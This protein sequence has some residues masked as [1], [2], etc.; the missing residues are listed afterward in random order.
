MGGVVEVDRLAR[1]TDNPGSHKVMEFWGLEA[2]VADFEPADGDGS[3]DPALYVVSLV[4]GHLSS[5]DAVAGGGFDVAQSAGRGGTAAGGT[6]GVGGIDDD[7]AEIFVRTGAFGV[8]LPPGRIDDG[9]FAVG[10]EAVGCQ[11]GRQVNDG[12]A[13][14]RR[15]GCRDGVAVPWR[16]ERRC[17][18]HRGKQ[19]SDTGDGCLGRRRGLCG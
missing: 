14:V 11:V 17:S 15:I 10:V 9:G 16:A 1:D 13:S 19:Q 18:G 4:R 6:P 8:G 2:A 5:K 7:L 12:R 3:D